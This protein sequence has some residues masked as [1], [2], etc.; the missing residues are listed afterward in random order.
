M[1]NTKYFQLNIRNFLIILEHFNYI[2]FGPKNG[3]DKSVPLVI[4][5]HG[6]PHSNYANAFTLDY[7]L[8][9]LSGK[10]FME[11]FRKRII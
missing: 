10:Y 7:A 1:K 6:G 3:E 4:V 2:Y 11:T 9:V 8:F 5:P